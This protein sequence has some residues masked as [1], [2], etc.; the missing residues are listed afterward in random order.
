MARPALKRL[1]MNYLTDDCQLSRRRA[2]RRVNLHRSDVY[3]R[4]RKDPKTALR[5]RKRELAQTRIRYGYRRLD[6]LLRR[7]AWT[8]G[9]NQAYRLYTAESLQLCSKRPRQGRM[10]VARQEPFVAK[11][12]NQ[13]W[14]MN[15]VAD[16]LVN[17]NKYRTLTIVDG[18]TRE[19]LAIEVGS[20][21]CGE[22]VL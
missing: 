13:A 12:A 19:A 11:R 3:Y 9:K 14:S 17:G 16:Q 7:E 21:L 4:S 10:R 6:V 1:A 15:Y 22:D 5:E 8:L 20:G 2:C 18:F